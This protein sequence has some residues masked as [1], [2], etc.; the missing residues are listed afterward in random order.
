MKSLTQ[1]VYNDSIACAG[2]KSTDFVNGAEPIGSICFEHFLQ[3]HRYH[4]T[5]LSDTRRQ[6][7]DFGRSE[8]NCQF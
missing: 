2:T 8:L 6:L 7:L 1:M 3:F 4:L 5:N